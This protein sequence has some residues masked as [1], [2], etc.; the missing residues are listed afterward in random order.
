MLFVQTADAVLK[1]ADAYLYKK[2]GLSV[3]K[4]RVLRILAANGGP[5]IPSEIAKRT[6]RDR[7]NITTLVA[8]LKRDGLV[9]TGSNSNDKRCVNVTLTDRGWEVLNQAMP[10]TWEVVSQVMSSLAEGDVDLFEEPLG[11][12]RQNACDGLEHL[13]KVEK[14]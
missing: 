3:I 4:F 8:R 11:I 6:L 7:H 10:V 14:P 5:M 9:T 1:Y 2:T 13:A 12:L